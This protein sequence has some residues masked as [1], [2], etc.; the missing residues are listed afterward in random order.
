MNGSF[1]MDLVRTYTDGSRICS[2]SQYRRVYTEVTGLAS[3]S[4]NCKWY[5]S[6]PLDAVVLLFWV[7]CLHTLCVA[8]QRVCIVVSVYFF[9]DSV[10]KR[11]DTPS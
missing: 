1:M 8:S 9:I 10:R 4:E 2:V 3:W 11:L 5:S 6:L 7:Y